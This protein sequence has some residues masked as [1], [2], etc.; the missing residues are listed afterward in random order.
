[1]A[2]KLRNLLFEEARQIIAKTKPDSSKT[3]SRTWYMP[4]SELNLTFH[5]GI[6]IKIIRIEATEHR[7]GR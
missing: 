7:S 1:M 2:I 6:T 3:V 5:T 4:S